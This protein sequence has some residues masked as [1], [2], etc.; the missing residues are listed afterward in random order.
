MI[1]KKAKNQPK[2]KSSSKLSDCFLRTVPKHSE[3]PD[4]KNSESKVNT[5]IRSLV[6]Q[7]KNNLGAEINRISVQFNEI[8]TTLSQVVDRIEEIEANSQ[9]QDTKIEQQEKQINILE[10]R[11]EELER[12]SKLNSVIISWPG[13]RVTSPNIRE[14]T[15]TFMLNELKLEANV[16]NSSRISQFGRQRQIIVTLPSLSAKKQLFKVKKE[17]FESD[18]DRYKNLFINEL[19]TMKKLEFLRMARDLK[20][21]KK[22]H[23]AFSFDGNIYIKVRA[24]DDRKLIRRLSDFDELKMNVSSVVED[25]EDATSN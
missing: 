13:L 21:K 25:Y 6:D 8:F 17:L 9:C 14:D 19:L 15:K 2:V 3:N 4:D 5:D 1:Q 12:K 18:K 23:A 10:Q 22:I 7:V 20:K 16:V 24:D 11:T